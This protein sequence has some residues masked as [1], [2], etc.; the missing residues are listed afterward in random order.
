MPLQRFY[1]ETD[2]YIALRLRTINGNML[3]LEFTLEN[4]GERS[5]PKQCISVCLSV[6]Q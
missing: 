3:L 6:T 5:T 4:T 1:K 2:Y